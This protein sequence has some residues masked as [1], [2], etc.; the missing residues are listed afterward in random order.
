MFLATAA[1]RIRLSV[2]VTL[3]GRVS[4]MR[5]VC[6]LGRRKRRPLLKP[7]G[8]GWPLER[9]LKTPKRTGAERE[10]TARQAANEM[11]S[12]PAVELLV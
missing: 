4:E 2:L 7:G 5:P 6:F 9:A 1:A 10:G 3:R 11:P 8:G 12:G